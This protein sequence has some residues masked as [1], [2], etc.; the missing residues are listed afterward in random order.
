MVVRLHAGGPPV[1]GP[2]HDIRTISF[3]FP[4]VGAD[5]ATR[6]FKAIVVIDRRRHF[7]RICATRDEVTTSHWLEPAQ[8]AIGHRAALQ[9]APL[10]QFLP[11]VQHSCCFNSTQNTQGG[12]PGRSLGG[13]FLMALV[14]ENVTPNRCLPSRGH[15]GFA[16]HASHCSSSQDFARRYTKA[17]ISHRFPCPRF[18]FVQST[19]ILCDA[20]YCAANILNPD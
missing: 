1:S 13:R 14:D 2:D 17:L 20:N 11:L 6:M 8:M 4:Q 7:S 19:A 10:L 12:A 9:D 3:S 5:V 18:H 15:D 16:S